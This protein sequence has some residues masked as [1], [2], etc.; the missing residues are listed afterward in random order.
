MITIV[1]WIASN[2]VLAIDKCQITEHA[3]TKGLRDEGLFFSALARSENL[4]AYGKN[5][6]LPALV[7][8]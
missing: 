3:N 2:A 5:S 6:D 1:E 8:S 7:A 4:H